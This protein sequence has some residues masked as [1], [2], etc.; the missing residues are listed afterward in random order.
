MDRLKQLETFVSVAN[1]GS[2]SAAARLEG[3]APAVVSRRLDAL[4]RRLGAKLMV[5][6][7]RRLTLTFE[8]RA[9][10]ADA[11]RVL[12]DL[13]H[14]ESEVGQGG[15]V[16]SGHVR[17]SAPAGFGRKHV[18]PLVLR[19]MEENPQVSVSLD[20]SDRLVDLVNERIDCAV[21]IGELADSNLV[22]TRLTEMRRVV[23]ASPDYLR[24]QGVP[25]AP[26]ELTRHRCLLLSQ[27]R[28]WNF[29][30]DGQ[31]VVL[32]VAG[33][34]E[35]NDGAVLHEWALAGHGLAWRSVWEVDED[36]RDGRLVS[37]LD[38]F[39]APPMGV[40]AV[41]PDRQALPLRVRL[42]INMLK[43]AYARESYWNV[44]VEAPAAGSD[45]AM[46]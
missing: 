31:A 42:F 12:R 1:L 5:R 7:T 6:T 29:V 18:A 17:I 10:L 26:D 38:A 16:A 32:K 13:A 28:G 9:F 37:V 22:S 23:V 25:R 27:Q 11:E 2:L 4:E 15:S 44:P 34:F 24:R 35:S 40:H 36:L 46:A 14:A 43:E 33:P 8:G 39:A 41:F 21:R 3:V 30:V 20:L 45:H 19:F